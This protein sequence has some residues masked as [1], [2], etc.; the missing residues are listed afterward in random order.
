[1]TS[2]PDERDTHVKADPDA[3]DRIRAI[4]GSEAD[5][6]VLMLNLNRYSSA[7][8]F[9]DG[10]KYGDYMAA[11]DRAVGA[12]G[13]SVLWRSPV[14]DTVI[15]CGHDAYDEVLAVW[16]P[17]HAAFVDLPSA[18]GADAMFAGRRTCVENA[19]ILSFPGDRAP[20]S[21]SPSPRLDSPT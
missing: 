8:G 4:A 11:L 10:E 17:S 15:G 6:P 20:F 7:A 3:F 16:Y 1:M 21:P 18:D 9:P 13:G 14:I 19:A 12:A 5:R 2:G